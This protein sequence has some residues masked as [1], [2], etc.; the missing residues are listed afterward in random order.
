MVKVR[1]GTWILKRT[2]TRAETE[3]KTTTLCRRFKSNDTKNSFALINNEKRFS[4]IL[5]AEHT[6]LEKSNFHGTVV[7][8]KVK[9]V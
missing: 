4:N 5:L 6:R 3:I 7:V 8:A 1:I 2:R 9:K